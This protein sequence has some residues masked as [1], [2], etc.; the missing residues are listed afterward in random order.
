M[1]EHSR[2]QLAVYAIAAVLVVAAGVKLLSPNRGRSEDGPP[3]RLSRGATGSGGDG[4]GVYVHVAGAVRRP[5]LFRLPASARVAAAIQRAG[6]PRR[7]ADLA[8]VNLAAQLEDGQQIVVPRAGARPPP[9]GAAAGS[10]APGAG[11]KISLASATAEQLDQLEGIGPTLAKRILEH[12][13]AHGGFRSVEE[14]REVEGIGEKRF[15]ALR[16]AVT[17]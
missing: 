15:A 16:E 7:K 1:M 9:T 14:L 13:D 17:P 12:R 6:G 10:A 2:A 8:A 3:V 5:G 11:A 4:A